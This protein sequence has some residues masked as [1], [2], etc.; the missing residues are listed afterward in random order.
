MKE[1]TKEELKR[2]VKE[3]KTLR[4]VLIEFGRNDSSASYKTLKRRLKEWNI[5]TSHFF[6][7]KDIINNLQKNGVFKKY[8]DS[9]IF[10][11]D[12]KVNRGTVKK[13]LKD[14]IKYECAL[15]GQ[16]ENWNNMKIS[17][18]LDHINGIRNDNRIENLR[19]VCPNCNAALPTHCRGQKGLNIKK[20]ID[21]RVLKAGIPKIN[22]RKVER[23]PYE[24]LIDEIDKNG[25]RATGRKYGVSDNSIRKWI[26]FYKKTSIA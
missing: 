5:N 8:N 23:P 15:C 17:L 18:I 3:S 6:K 13:R 16:D 2:V 10:S 20:K 9:E 12:S 22:L 1:Y 14:C 21:G 25:Y 4:N 11:M 24:E 26:E 7:Q 19:F